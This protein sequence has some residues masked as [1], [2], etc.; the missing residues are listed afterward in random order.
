MILSLTNFAGRAVTGVLCHRLGPQNIMIFTTLIAAI[1]IFTLWYPVRNLAVNIVFF[2]LFGLCGSTGFSTNLVLLNN[3]LDS[4]VLPHGI[5][6]LYL[7]LG[8]STLCSGPIMGSILDYADGTDNT[9]TTVKPLIIF[10]GVIYLIACMISICIK[11]Y[12]KPQKGNPL[13]K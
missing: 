13:P 11:F 1:L 3:I 12:L 5:G 2:I 9:P 8:V 10:S 7:S 4:S 6:L